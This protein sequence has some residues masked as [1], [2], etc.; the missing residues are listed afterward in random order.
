M[1]ALRTLAN[2]VLAPLGAR[3]VKVEP[4]E[5][6]SRE[7][8][9]KADGRERPWDREFAAWIAQAEASGDDPNDLGDLAWADDPLR[10]ALERHYLPLVR[11]DSVVLEIGPGTGRLTRHLIGRCRSLIV[12]DYSRLACQWLNR[13]LAGRGQFEVHELVEPAL[14]MIA[15]T[16]IDVVLANGVFEHIDV[17]GT[18][19]FFEEFYRVLKPAGI[20]AF[21]FDNI[22]SDG[23]IRWC[24]KNRARRD[25]PSLFQFHHPDVICRLA[26]SVGFQSTSVRADQSRFAYAEIRKLAPGERLT[27]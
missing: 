15:D 7:W 22:M 17:A 20:A 27:I 2:A 1:D 10:H 19:Q 8:L 6:T 12:V 14:P 24:L 4:W 18:L 26:S 21:N 5:N 25:H 9:S 3:I 16:S 11:T 13:Y 23:G